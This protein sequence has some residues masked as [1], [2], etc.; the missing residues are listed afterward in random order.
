MPMSSA[1]AFVEIAMNPGKGPV[2][3]G[4]AMGIEQPIMSRLLLDLGPKPRYNKEHRTK[5]ID[6]TYSS[7]NMREQEYYLTYEGYKL[8]RELIDLMG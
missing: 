4:R 5:L 1:R 6:R 7:T 3:Y 2:A 8:M